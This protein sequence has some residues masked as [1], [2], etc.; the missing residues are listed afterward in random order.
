MLNKINQ[1]RVLNELND[2]AGVYE[3]YWH[4][5]ILFVVNE[6]DIPYVEHFLDT[7][8]W[9]AYVRYQSVKDDHPVYELA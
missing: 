6:Q 9:G 5:D 1:Q 4:K 3:V 8:E 7:T 2:L